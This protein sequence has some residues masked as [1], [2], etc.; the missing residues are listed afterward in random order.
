M[1]AWLHLRFLTE[2]R[3]LF[4]DGLKR[5]GYQIMEGLPANPGDDDLLVVWNRIG[6]GD[7]TA[8]KFKERGLR[9]LVV[10]NATWGNSFAG[11][12]WY[13][14]AIDYHNTSGCYPIGD[15]SRW[16]SLK[17]H[18]PEFRQRGETVILPQR[19]I[20][21]DPVRMPSWF[22]ET[23][24]E[25]HGGRVR[26]HPGKREIKPLEKDLEKCKTVVTWGSGAAIKALL[27][28]CHVISYMPN[29]IGEQDNTKEGRLAM[30]RRLAWA[31]WRW[32]EI[33]TGAAFDGLIHDD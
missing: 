25:E 10:E 24:L 28:G 31:Q 21:S 20:G 12:T 11:D 8:R 7:L 13:H 16:D 2:R 26:R 33:E 22:A 30:F 18:L 6:A 19:G 1:R 3:R 32:S 15:N 9:V 17:V 5:H 4:K 23:A 27:L 29:W 14:M